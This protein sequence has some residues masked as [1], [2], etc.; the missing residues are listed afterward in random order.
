MNGVPMSCSQ[1][2]KDLPGEEEWPPEAR[3]LMNKVIGRILSLQP[4]L[5]MDSSRGADPGQIA[6]IC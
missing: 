4:L 2:G 6:T 3:L 1:L 5:L